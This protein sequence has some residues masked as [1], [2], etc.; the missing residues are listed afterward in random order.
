MIRW[1]RTVR[2][3]G[4]DKFGRA[5]EFAE[6]TK[7]L[8]GRYP[9][10]DKIDVFLDVLGDMSCIRWMVDYPDLATL[11]KVQD[12]ILKD[13]DYWKLMTAYSDV[14]IAGSVHDV[15]LKKI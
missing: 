15:A 11:E 7:G 3:A 14:F 1:V 6:M 12:A 9:G 10:A 4:A 5:M 13:A 8:A 2:M